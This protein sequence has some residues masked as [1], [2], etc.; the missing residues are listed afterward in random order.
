MMI[1][2]T[3][4]N[5]MVLLVL[6]RQKNF[7]QIKGT[8]PSVEPGVI[9]QAPLICRVR[10]SKGIIPTSRFWKF[11]LCIVDPWSKTL[12]L[13]KQATRKPAWAATHLW[14]PPWCFSRNSLHTA[15]H[16]KNA[17]WP[18]GCGQRNEKTRK[19]ENQKTEKTEKTRKREIE[20]QKTGTLL[21]VF[22]FS[23]FSPFS[24][25]RVFAVFAFSRFPRF[26]GFLVFAVFAFS[27]FRRFRV[28]AFSP[29]SRFSCFRRFR[30]FAVFA[31]SLFSRPQVD[32]SR[33]RVFGF[34][35]FRVRRCFHMF[36]PGVFVLQNGL[37]R[38]ILYTCPKLWYRSCS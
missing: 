21:A 28:F 34:S 6:D 15:K 14:H 10:L 13:V 4:M 35:R 24:R 20:N 9:R 2:I 3:I 33:F 12:W 27:G 19:R 16:I 23:S 29:F 25:F 36:S 18:E 1:T 8:K 31:F 7:C 26:R 5:T 30:V 17:T 37:L 11:P 22:G 38:Y 32:S